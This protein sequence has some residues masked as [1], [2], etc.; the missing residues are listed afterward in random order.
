LKPGGLVAIS[1]FTNLGTVFFSIVSSTGWGTYDSSSYPRVYKN[2][3]LP[4][5]L[6]LSVI[7]SG[8][9]SWLSFGYYSMLLIVVVISS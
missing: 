5:L 1:S 3:K 4:Y 7:N 2:L 6:A 8:A 9:F